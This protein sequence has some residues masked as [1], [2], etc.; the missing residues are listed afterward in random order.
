MITKLIEYLPCEDTDLAW[1][2]LTE[3]CEE[4][5]KEN[6]RFTK[7]GF[8]GSWCGPEYGGSF[9]DSVEYLRGHICQDFS[10]RM[11]FTLEYTDCD[12]IIAPTQRYCEPTSIS[13]P[14]GSLILKQ[15]HHDGCNVYFLR[16]YIEGDHPKTAVTEP[17]NLGCLGEC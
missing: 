3:I 14:A 16:K 7:W 12:T 17:V 9:I 11:G 5:L 1:D 8:F 15:W 13:I 6:K 2:R 4:L 10:V